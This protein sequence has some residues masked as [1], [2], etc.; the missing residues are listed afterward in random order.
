MKY[1]IR[2]KVEIDGMVDKNDVIGALFG[3]TEGLLSPELDLRELQDKGRIGRIQVDLKPVNGKIKGEIKIPSNLDRVETALIAALLETIDKVGPYTAKIQI[4]KIV[5]LRVEKLKKAVDRAK[6]L[7]KTWQASEM[8]DIKDLLREI[9]A[10]LKPAEIIEYGPEK[11]PAGSDAEKSDEL[12]IVEGRADIL[13][14]LRY[15][16]SNTIAVEGAKESIPESVKQLAAKKKKVI[17]FVDGDHGGELILRTLLN[18]TKIDYVARAPPGK[19]VEDLV[20]KEIEQA[21]QNAVPVE[22]YKAEIEHR[23]ERRYH[24]PQKPEVEQVQVLAEAQPP[25][26]VEVVP[27]IQAQPV[28]VTVEIPENVMKE[29]SELRG[30]LEAILYDESWNKIGRVPVRDLYAELEKAEA[31]KIRAVV[32][33]GIVTQRIMDAASSKGVKLIVAARIGN[34]A[35][36]G[37]GVTLLTI[38]DLLG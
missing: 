26:Q 9:Q 4:V 19:E 8:P 15:G 32:F 6:E 37:E 18:S 17:A 12:I 30:T 11:L 35:K 31:G 28:P 13:N 14:L 38:G 2:A 1:L 3:Q 20:G 29:I 10:A 33:D 16:Y 27:P 34:I 24:E 5:D 7:L 23:A 21:L 22:Q 36:R 25:Q